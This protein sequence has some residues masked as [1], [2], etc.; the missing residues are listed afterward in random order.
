MYS[1]IRVDLFVGLFVLF[2]LSLLLLS[3]LFVVNLYGAKIG[4]VPTLKCFYKCHLL[5]LLL[6]LLSLLP[7]RT[8]ACRTV[9]R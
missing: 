1:C 2:S 6:L 3:P 8:T 7:R 9:T 5:L 4:D